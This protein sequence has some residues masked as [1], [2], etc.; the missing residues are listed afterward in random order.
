M[1][2]SADKTVS[3]EYSLSIENGEV[4]DSNVDGEPLT[5]VQGKHQIFSAVEEAI[6]GMSSGESTKVVIPS[7]RAYG[8]VNPDAIVKAPIESLPED[9][10]TVGVVVQSKSSKGDIMKGQVIE[11]GSD[12]ASIDFNHPLAGNAIHFD[13]KILSV[14]I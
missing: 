12:E 11:V 5:F 13:V 6:L 1:K 14:R 4:I 9:A 8:P 10:R 7:E 2:I 3:I